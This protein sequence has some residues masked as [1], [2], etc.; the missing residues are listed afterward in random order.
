[1]SKNLTITHESTFNGNKVYIDKE[2]L[3]VVVN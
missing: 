1:M 3:V 2:G